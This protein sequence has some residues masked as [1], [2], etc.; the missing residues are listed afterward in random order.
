MGF[1]GKEYWSGLPF[2]STVNLANPGIKPWSPALQQIVY[3]LSYKGS[4]QIITAL[5]LF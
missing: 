1:F 2:P 3:L 5:F 4:L